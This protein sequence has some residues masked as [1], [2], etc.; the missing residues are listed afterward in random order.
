MRS[1]SSSL[2]WG[3]S[4]STI[5]KNGKTKEKAGADS[6]AASGSKKQTRLCRQGTRS[7]GLRVHPQGEGAA[8]RLDAL[9]DTQ[10]HVV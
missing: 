9:S 1:S 6:D 10:K 2:F 5:F 3:L 4:V 7:G 8:G